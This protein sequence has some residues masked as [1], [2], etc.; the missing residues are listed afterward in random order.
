MKALSAFMAFAA[1]WHLGAHCALAA[2][3]PTAPPAEPPA[4]QD[5]SSVAAPVANQ[6]APVQ[7]GAP[8]EYTL[9]IRQYAEGEIIGEMYPTLGSDL[10]NPLEMTQICSAKGGVGMAAHIP[11]C[12]L[13]LLSPGVQPRLKHSM[14]AEM[15]ETLKGFDQPPVRE[16]RFN[17]WRICYYYPH[18]DRI[19][20]AFVR[21][22]AGVQA[23]ADGDWGGQFQGEVLD[24]LVVYQQAEPLDREPDDAE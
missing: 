7:P 18:A 1:A 23:I 21:T 6:P 12:Y 5:Q 13:L 15:R 14:E 8:D 4:T 9:S 3:P 16:I 2:E 22:S 11:V 24:R 19:E 10:S 20:F 17:G